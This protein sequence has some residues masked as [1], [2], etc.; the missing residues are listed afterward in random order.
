MRIIAV[1]AVV[2]L[3]ACG[4]DQATGPTG[5]DATTSVI[6]TVGAGTTPTLS[7][8]PACNVYFVIVEDGGGGDQ[9]WVTDSTGDTTTA[10]NS[11]AGPITY[12]IAPLATNENPDGPQP[13]HAD[14]AYHLALWRVMPSTAAASHCQGQIGKLCLVALKYFTP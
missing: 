4:A 7:W 3:I 1:L 13:L 14:T 9:W 5:C 12:G 10:A 11:I 6:A 2:A 8:T